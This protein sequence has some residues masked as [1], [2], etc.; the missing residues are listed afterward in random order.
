VAFPLLHDD[1]TTGRRRVSRLQ[2]VP[3]T[4]TTKAE[5]TMERTTS[6]EMS[7]NEKRKQN[8]FAELANTGDHRP[9]PAAT[10]LHYTQVKEQQR[11]EQEAED[12]EPWIKNT[13]WRITPVDFTRMGNA[14]FR[15]G[16]ERLRDR[17][18]ASD[19]AGCSS[20]TG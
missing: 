19:E 13:R 17:S 10:Q 9:A 5:K 11:R 14:A 18:D 20:A 16:V 4:K 3:S 1:L 15:T 8:L 7:K 6:E 12:A 2:R